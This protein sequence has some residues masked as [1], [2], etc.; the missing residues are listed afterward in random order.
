[1]NLIIYI[2]LL[3]VLESVLFPSQVFTNFLYIFC[4]SFSD[5][6]FGLHCELHLSCYY[7][8]KFVVVTHS[9]LLRKESLPDILD[10]TSCVEVAH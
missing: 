7:I 2:H 9:L 4:R 6:R 8:V 5:Y 10:I 3:P 1:V